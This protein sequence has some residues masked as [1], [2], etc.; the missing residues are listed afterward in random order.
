[1]KLEKKGFI[2]PLWFV[3]FVLFCFVWGCTR[4][5]LGREVGVEDGGKEGHA[6][7][8]PVLHLSEVRRAGI[9]A[10]R[11]RERGREVST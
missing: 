1:M 8:H 6:N 10:K 7:V 3:C 9:A 2:P 4:V 5:G 11:E